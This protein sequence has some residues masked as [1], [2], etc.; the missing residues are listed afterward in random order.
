[1]LKI[2]QLT[3]EKAQ[4]TLLAGFWLPTNPSQC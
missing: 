3:T 2:R 1:M 4:S